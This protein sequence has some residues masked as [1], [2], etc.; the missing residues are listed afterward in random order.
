M[1]TDYKGIKIPKEIILVEKIYEDDKI[2]QAYVVEKGNKNSLESA[3]FW[4]KT[5]YSDG[6]IHEYVNGNFKI[7]LLDSAGHSTQGGKLSFWDCKLTT[8]DGKEFSVGINSDLLIDI[9]KNNTWINGECQSDKVW[10]GRVKGNQVGVFTENLENFKQAQ[11]DELK[12]NAKKTS[13]YKVGDI[14]GSLNLTEAYCGEFYQLFDFN[15]ASYWSNDLVITIYTKPKKIYGYA[16]KHWQTEE[17]SNVTFSKTKSPKIVSGERVETTREQFLNHYLEL[18]ERFMEKHT[19]YVV[20]LDYFQCSTKQVPITI[21]ELK[22]LVQKTA[23]KF[24]LGNP[25]SKGQVTIKYE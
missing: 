21:E 7:A 25:F 18:R 24:G 20:P 3:L 4:A 15:S 11:K 10:L 22:E 19:Y 9:L 17:Y 14:V 12:R 23:D 2:H 6:V 5:S 1:A 16:H 13:S 8:P